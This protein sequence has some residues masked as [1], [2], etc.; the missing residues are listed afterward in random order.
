MEWSSLQP[1]TARDAVTDRIIG[2]CYKIHISFQV[3]KFES[4]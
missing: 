3:L 1:Q 2:C 4:C